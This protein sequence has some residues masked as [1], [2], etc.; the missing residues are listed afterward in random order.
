[1]QF[2]IDRYATREDLL[3]L[4]NFLNNTEYN[5]FEIDVIE[6]ENEGMSVALIAFILDGIN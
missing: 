2:S 1:M 4:Y 6:D 5:C 3:A